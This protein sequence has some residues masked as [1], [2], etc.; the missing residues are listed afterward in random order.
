[1]IYLPRVSAHLGHYPAQTPTRLIADNYGALPRNRIF[2]GLDFYGLV[3][4]CTIICKATRY[5]RCFKA[6]GRKK[7][8]HA[9]LQSALMMLMVRMMMMMLTMTTTTTTTTMMITLIITT[10][11]NSVAH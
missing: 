7:F 11:F 2:V 1:V 3:K 9:V 8:F 4:T 5:V 6:C 10:K